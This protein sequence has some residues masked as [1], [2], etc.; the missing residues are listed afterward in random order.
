MK[1]VARLRSKAADA[2]GDRCYYCEQPM[3]RDHRRAFARRHGLSREQSR[4]FRV[5]AEHLVPRSE[6]GKT[7]ASNIVAACHHCNQQR[8]RGSA[9]PSSEQYRQEVQTRIA[10][11]QWLLLIPRDPPTDRKE[12][13]RSSPSSCQSSRPATGGWSSA[14]WRRACTAAARWFNG[15]MKGGAK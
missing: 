11:G 1:R 9:R 10:Q 7:S 14:L 5:T 12:G 15:R 8:H 13:S 4:L 6:G 3:W 2:Q